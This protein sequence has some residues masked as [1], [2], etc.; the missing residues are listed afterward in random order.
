MQRGD[1][2]DAAPD[3]AHASAKRHKAEHG[4]G[5]GASGARECANRDA[6][7]PARFHDGGLGER[8]RWRK[9]E[10]LEHKRGLSRSEA[11]RLEAERRADAEREVAQLNA[12][13][14]QRERQRAERQEAE[15][16]RARRA[17]DAATAEWISREDEFL[18]EQAKRR[19]AIR[20]RAGRAKPIDV[21]VLNLQWADP[22][23]SSEND[24]DDSQFTASEDEEA[25]LD[26]SLEAPHALLE[27]MGVADLEEL[28]GELR[29]LLGLERDERCL[30]YWRSML[31]VCDDRLN[32]AQG[33]P[34][35]GAPPA[36]IDPSIAAEADAMLGSKSPEELTALQQSIRAKLRS[37]EP[38]DVEY[39]ETL[40]RR[41]VVWRSIGKLRAVHEQALTNR[42]AYL[43]RLQRREAQR[44][45]LQLQSEKA[46]GTAGSTGAEDAGRPDAGPSKAPFLPEMEPAVLTDDTLSRAQR[47]LP[48]VT[49]EEQRAALRAARQDVLR[50]AFVAR[51]PPPARARRQARA[52]NEID[53]LEQAVMDDMG[54]LEAQQVLDAEEE[55]FTEDVRMMQPHKFDDKYRARKPRYLN[56]VHTGYEWN[57]YNQTHYDRENPPPKVVQGYK[58]NI[59]YPDLIDPSKAPTYRIIRDSAENADDATR[60]TVLLRFS[61]GPPYEDIAFRIVDREWELSHLRGFRNSFDRGVLQLYCA[62]SAPASVLTCSQL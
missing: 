13:R 4:G 29:S 39:W 51:A 27:R 57:Q 11:E 8:F 34:A 2:D 49:L 20:M 44:H 7:P 40:L 15:A 33:M 6:E 41:I 21:L 26:L 1:W 42:I 9:K 47:E 31:I 37:G 32:N 54:R 5:G 10:A 19:A 12:R 14:E 18:L 3:P 16:R 23:R 38:L 56:R 62:L 28:H 22:V 55:L 52:A 30:D 58:F 61:A 50:R 53:A 17:E 43:Q 46:G 36:R 60:G 35:A 25:G 45:E 48:I 59:F 24:T